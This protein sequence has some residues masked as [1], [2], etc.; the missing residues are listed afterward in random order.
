MHH[1]NKA[2]LRLRE[3]HDVI[4]NQAIMDINQQK[5]ENKTVKPH[6]SIHADFQLHL[7]NP[8]RTLHILMLLVNTWE[9]LPVLALKTEDNN[10][11]FY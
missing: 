10:L 11:I 2:Q 8:P 1:L 5:K 9:F 4:D 6:Q 3:L 7:F